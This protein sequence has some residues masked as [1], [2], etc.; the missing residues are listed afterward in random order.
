MVLQITPVIPFV[1]KYKEHRPLNHHLVQ[2]MPTFGTS[3]AGLGLMSY[4]CN[5]RIILNLL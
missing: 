2:T 3:N 5:V 1:N 4:L